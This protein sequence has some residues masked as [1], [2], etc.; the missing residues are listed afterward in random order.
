MGAG[1]AAAMHLIQRDRP[2]VVPKDRVGGIS[3]A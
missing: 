3:F 1:A 2:D